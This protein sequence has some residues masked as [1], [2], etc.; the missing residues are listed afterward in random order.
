MIDLKKELIKLDVGDLFDSFV[1]MKKRDPTDDELQL[2]IDHFTD[3][4]TDIAWETI[5]MLIVDTINSLED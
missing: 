1:E 3:E 5:D 2:M 4:N